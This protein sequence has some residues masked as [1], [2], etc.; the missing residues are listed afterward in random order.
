MSRASE[1]G[2]E[3]QTHLVAALNVVHFDA[4]CVANA[5]SELAPTVAWRLRKLSS[6]GVVAGKRR[7]ILLAAS[8][9]TRE[10]CTHRNWKSAVVMSSVQT[11]RGRPRAFARAM[12]REGEELR[13]DVG[14][15]SVDVVP[16]LVDR[17]CDAQMGKIFIAIKTRVWKCVL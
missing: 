12:R 7:R 11:V 13:G 9:A 3:L 17:V 4:E 1:R 2:Q 5:R 6:E 16:R 15:V 14:Q 10:V 8:M